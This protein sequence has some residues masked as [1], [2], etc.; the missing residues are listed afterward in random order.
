MCDKTT[1]FSVKIKTQMNYTKL[2]Y[3]L[4]ILSLSL[5]LI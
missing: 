3:L 2:N 1:M 4:H 5:A